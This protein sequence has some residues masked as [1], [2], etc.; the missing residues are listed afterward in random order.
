MLLCPYLG[1]PPKCTVR[2]PLQ[3]RW[4]TGHWIWIFLVLSEVST[5][6]LMSSSVLRFLQYFCAQR[7]GKAPGRLAQ[8]PDPSTRGSELISRGPVFLFLLVL[9]A[10][11]NNWSF[12]NDWGHSWLSPLWS[13]SDLISTAR[14]SGPLP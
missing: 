14:T 2:L 5:S 1:C 3:E 13:F 10:P 8:W 7:C 11:A 6:W 12:T 4:T 9:M